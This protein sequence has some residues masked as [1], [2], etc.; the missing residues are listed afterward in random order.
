M[1]LRS[2]RIIPEM[3][4]PRGTNVNNNNNNN[5][6]NNNNANNNANQD[7]DDVNPL[8]GH[9][10]GSIPMTTSTTDA[11]SVGATQTISASGTMPSSTS[12]VE[13]IMVE[14][15][16]IMPLQTTM[17]L[18]TTSPFSGASFD[19]RNQTEGLF[20]SNQTYPYGMPTSMMQNMYSHPSTYSERATV[21]SPYQV[22]QTS[23]NNRVRVNQPTITT[24]SLLSIRQQMDDSNHEMVNQ[25]TSQLGTVINPLIRDT[26][27]SYEALATQMG[28][29]ADFF[30][31]PQLPVQQPLQRIPPRIP[32]QV[33]KNRVEV[34]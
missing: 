31:G 10:V 14:N 25:L 6:N 34:N 26:N 4:R 28:R 2:G 32:E 16:S 1:Q 33:V 3:V 13:T 5:D 29:I 8:L 15:T 20:H 22:G 24:D 17:P 18:G 21:R 9:V 19:F 11:T 30:G 7:P 27:R 12:N 23:N